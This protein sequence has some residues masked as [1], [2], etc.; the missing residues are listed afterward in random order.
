MVAVLVTAPALVT[1]PVTV[2][3]AT[4]LAGRFTNP[5]T[6]LPVEPVVVHV[7]PPVVEH[8]TPTDPTV[9][10]TVSAIVAVPGP[11]PLLV[12]VIV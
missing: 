6:V 10:G 2:Y 4:A 7:P 1:T 3:V 11:L 12:T 8:V 9:D 5:A